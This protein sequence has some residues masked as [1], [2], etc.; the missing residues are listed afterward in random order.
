[1]QLLKLTI[2]FT[3]NFLYYAYSQT[4]II[5]KIIITIL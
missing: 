3:T 5:D 4:D 2:K 1:M